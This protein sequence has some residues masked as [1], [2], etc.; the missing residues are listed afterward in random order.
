MCIRDSRYS[1]DISKIANEL[2]YEPQVPFAEGLA[3]TVDWYRQNRAWWEPLKAAA[4]TA[5]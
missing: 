3:T 4:A 1:V 5:R 2:G